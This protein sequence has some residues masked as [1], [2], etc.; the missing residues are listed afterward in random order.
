MRITKDFVFF[1]TA[2]DFLSQWHQTAFTYNVLTFKTA[3]HWMM[4]QK[5]VLFAIPHDNKGE[6]VR[7]L[8]LPENNSHIANQILSA[9]SPKEAKAL[10]RRVPH[11]NQETWELNVE[12]ILYRGNYLKMTQNPALLEQFLSFGE[13]Q[14]VEA[15]PYDKIY[16]IGMKYDNPLATQPDK[17][18]GKNLLGN[19]LTKLSNDLRNP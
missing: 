18:R 1:W 15:S 19:A 6:V 3:E 12:S 13:R 2:K 17:W 4:F 7:F 14:F 10:G 8:S 9:K 5:A 11:F 16:G